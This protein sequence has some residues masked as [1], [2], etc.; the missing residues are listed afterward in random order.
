MFSGNF[1][2][3]ASN[4]A[5]TP[6]LPGINSDTL[7]PMPALIR[8]GQTVSEDN[9]QIDDEEFKSSAWNLQKV[10]T[11]S[12]TSQVEVM[13]GNGT[14]IVL[15]ICGCSTSNA[16][17]RRFHIRMTLCE[18]TGLSPNK[19]SLYQSDETTG[20]WIAILSGDEDTDQLVYLIDGLILECSETFYRYICTNVHTINWLLLDSIPDIYSETNK[21]DIDRMSDRDTT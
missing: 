1:A 9:G 4:E 3:T 7:L 18:E 21:S 2:P 16:L 13:M 15:Q 6:G 19:F 5:S 12:N 11:C 17:H 10:H 20:Q 14:T 8:C